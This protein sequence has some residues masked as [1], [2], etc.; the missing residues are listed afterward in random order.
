MRRRYI[1]TRGTEETDA[2]YDT[3]DGVDERQFQST[4]R[5]LPIKSIVFILGFLIAGTFCLVTSVL[6]LSG[7]IDEKYNDRIWPLFILGSILMIPGGYY[8]YILF[9]IVLR[10]SNYTIDDI[11]NL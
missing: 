5:S 6:I 7:Y 10:I 3:A 4:R 11:P 8:G 2:L 9:C 1:A